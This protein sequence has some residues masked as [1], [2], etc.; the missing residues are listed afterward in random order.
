MF[1]TNTVSLYT[2]NVTE[3]AKGGLIH[4]SNFSN[5]RMRNSASIGPTALNFGS[6]TSLSLY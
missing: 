6:R 1:N 2:I 3:F 4:T 5:L